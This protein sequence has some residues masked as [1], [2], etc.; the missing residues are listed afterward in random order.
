MTKASLTC[1]VENGTGKTSTVI[2]SNYI[3]AP[4]LQC[5]YARSQPLLALGQ[6]ISIITIKAVALGESTPV[7][8]SRRDRGS[9]QVSP[10]FQ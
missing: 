4:T 3:Q 2:E 8:A 1:L 10:L 7:I 6:D 9:F 5:R